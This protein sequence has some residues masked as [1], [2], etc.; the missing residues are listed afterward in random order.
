MN[1]FSD[2]L[3]YILFRGRVVY[4]LISIRELLKKRYIVYFAKYA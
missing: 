1:L 4:Q 2:S 3:K